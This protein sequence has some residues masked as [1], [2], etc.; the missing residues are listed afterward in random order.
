MNTHC[1]IWVHT[2][3]TLPTRY[4]PLFCM[5]DHEDD[6]ESLARAVGCEDD[7]QRRFVL[8]R[9]TDA[10]TGATVWRA[11]FATEDAA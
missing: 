9:I 11:A 5:A 3:G 10:A 8:A 7:Y 6:I 4:I 2:R 1:A